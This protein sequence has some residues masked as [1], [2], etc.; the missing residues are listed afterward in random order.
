[1]RDKYGL[2]GEKLGHSYSPQIHALLADYPYDLYEVAP[3]EV[4]KFLSETDLAGMNVTIPYKQTVMPYLACISD[5]AKRIGSVNTLVRRPDGWHG[6]N[7]DYDGFRYMVEEKAGYFV[8]GKKG[9]IFGNGGVSLAVRTALADMGA[10][11]VVIVSRRGPVFYE[12]TKEY[13]D[14]DFIVQ[15]TPVGMAPHTG[16]SVQSLDVFDHPAAVFD[17][18]YNPA[19]TP[20]LRQAKERGI[21][22]ENGLSML[23]VQA[24]R[25]CELFTGTQI[26][27]KR[28]GEVLDAM[29]EIVQGR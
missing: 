6:Y 10:G 22:A 2:L 19:E 12:D 9:V 14:A 5:E 18:I 3:D 4:E 11:Q 27:N 1:M 15:A 24:V 8:R 25:A 16:K 28:I 20:I 7:T 26:G 13:A 17:L 29:E 23:V 21:I